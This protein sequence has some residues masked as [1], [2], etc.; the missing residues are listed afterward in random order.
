MSKIDRKIDSTR[1]HLEHLLKIIQLVQQGNFPENKKE[2]EFEFV[3][4]SLSKLVSNRKA[5]N[6]CCIYVLEC[7]QEKYYVGKVA[8]E[9]RVDERFNQH[10]NGVGAV[11]TKK[12]KPICIVETIEN[13]SPFEEDAY[14]IKLMSKYGIDNVRGGIFSN[15]TLSTE[16]EAVITRMIDGALD[17]CYKCGKTGH[18]A[19]ECDNTES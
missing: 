4:N 11:F 10:I 18:F 2:L 7:E 3:K 17:R 13:V 9:S 14:V 15:I 19:K 1:L 5:Q 12:F 8:D 16:E 6:S